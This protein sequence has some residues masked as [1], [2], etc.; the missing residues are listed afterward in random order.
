MKK[1]IV[2]IGFIIVRFC[3]P[4][5]CQY[6]IIEIIDTPTANSIELGS[7]SF[8]TRLYGR[9]SILTRLFYG[10]IMKDLTLGL[11]FD[12]KGVI[13]TEDIT[14]HRPYLYI[15]VPL[16]SGSQKWPVISLGFDEQGLG[17]FDDDTNEYRIPPIGFFLVFTKMGLTTGL[18]L[19]VGVNANYSLVE[20]TEDKVLGFCSVD[21]MLGPEFMLITEVKEI[22]AWDSYINAG[23]RYLVNPELSFEFSGLNLGSRNGKPERILK[24]IYSKVWKGF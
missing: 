1:I 8:S 15:K 12:A 9:G 22:T 10:I 11:S 21:F 13:G 3:N 5:F 20:N 17:E 14:A 19:S 23:A 2:I 16:Y 4:V 18:N 24:V 7:Y 6:K